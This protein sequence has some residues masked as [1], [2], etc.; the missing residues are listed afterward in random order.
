VKVVLHLRRLGYLVVGGLAAMVGASVWLS[1]S[2]GAAHFV[3]FAFWIA[4]IV[5]PGALYRRTVTTAEDGL[6]L[7][8]GALGQV[9]CPWS[10]IVGVE[11]RQLW[12][13][14]MDQP[15]LREPVRRHLSYS[16]T[17]PPDVT[18][19]PTSNKRLFI[20][21]YDKNWRTGPIGTA[22]TAHGVSLRAMTP[23][24]NPVVN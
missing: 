8:R 23:R 9:F 11:K 20:G 17:S 7:R 4:A 6:A 22:M 14:A 3:A 21:L 13:F 2:T 1:G 12:P 19:R 24:R 10:E 18:W 15:Q 5:A 16:S